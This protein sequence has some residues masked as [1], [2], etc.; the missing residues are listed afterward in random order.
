MVEVKVS[1]YQNTAIICSGS[2]Y[3]RMRNRALSRAEREN[4]QD[5]DYSS[6]KQY[7][8]LLLQ[9]PSPYSMMFNDTVSHICVLYGIFLAGPLLF[10]IL[11]IIFKTSEREKDEIFKEE[12]KRKARE[13]V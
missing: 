1:I 4:L 8:C 10:F 12:M 6:E 2:M 9:Q 7:S 11:Y 5:C 13:F 3:L